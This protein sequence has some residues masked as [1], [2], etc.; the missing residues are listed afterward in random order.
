MIKIVSRLLVL[1]LCVTVPVTFL[2]PQEVDPGKEKP[3]DKKQAAEKKGKQDNK[4]QKE[5]EKEKPADEGVDKETIKKKDGKDITLKE[6][7]VKGEQFI[8]K[9]PY[10]I[11]VVNSNDIEKKG[12][13]RTADIIKSV[14]GV[15]MHE[16]DQGGVSNAIAIRGFQ[17]GVHGGDMGVYLD[18]IPLNE[19]YGHGGGYAD[20]NI[21][22]PLELDKV[23]VYKGPSS[24]LYGNFSR[25]GT[26]VYM[27]KKGGDYI[28]VNTKYGSWNT[29]DVQ[30]ALG[31]TIISDKLTNNT[32]VQL[33]RTDGFQ[34]NSKQ[35]YGNGS[36]RFTYK[37]TSDLEITLSLRAHGDDWNSPGYYSRT[38]WGMK[39]YAYK[40]QMFN[41]LDLPLDANDL[42]QNDGGNR[43]QFTERLDINYTVNEYVKILAWGFG[44]QTNWTRFSKFGS[45]SQA[46]QD[47]KIGKYGTGISANLDVPLYGDSKL[48]AILGY[49]YFNDDTVYRRYQTLNRTRQDYTQKKYS[50]FETHGFFLET[51]WSL[52][53]YFTPVIG[54]RADL[55]AGKYKN[56]MFERDVYNAADAMERWMKFDERHKTINPSDYNYISPKFGFIS[57]IVKDILRFRA[58]A[59]NGFVMPPDTTIFQ[60]WQHL[61]PSKI[62]QYEGGLTATYEKYLWFDVTG[63]MIDVTNEAN[64]YPAGS[65]IYR[66]MGTTR[67][68]GIESAIKIMPF[69]YIE[70]DGT[71]TWMK[72]KVLEIPIIGTNA[73]T[74]Y[75][76]IGNHLAKGSPLPNVP[77]YGAGAEFIWSS[78][79]GLGG[80]F[81]W[82]YVGQQY[83]DSYGTRTWSRA[84]ILNYLSTLYSWGLSDAGPVYKGYNL[85]DLYLSYT[86]EANNYPI[87]FRFDAKNILNEHYAGYAGG[88]SIWSPGAPRS[89]YGSVGMK[90]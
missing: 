89:F 87:T 49:E 5:D 30:S 62:W 57:E 25:G 11:N 46:E 15:K 69:K 7:V 24:A 28:D 19:Y 40:Q 61:K 17:S 81:G 67:R 82:T 86:I 4:K 38:Q 56:A 77:E 29:V 41:P 9:S 60:K 72:S 90:F 14:P 59:S 65:G 55:F 58:N 74:Y 79:I 84:L 45:G 22:I 70:L 80:G 36:T 51:E 31:K 48:K 6:I 75:I 83:T 1:V 53:Q 2:Y 3:A 44:L 71:F 66:N 78:P 42:A 47:Y 8:K 20:P 10:T 26:I 52:H 27:T 34:S 50:T 12:I 39:K 33:Y 54:A 21:L 63:Y 64:E 18:G 13:S 23:L 68:W 32:A 43:R 37:P 35:L 73:A 76:N 88:L 85:F 16:Y